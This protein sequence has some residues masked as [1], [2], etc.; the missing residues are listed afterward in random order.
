VPDDNDILDVADRLWRG[1]IAIEQ[2]HPFAPRGDVAEVADGC[3]FVPS[4]ANVSAV[5]TG[6]GLVLVDTGSQLFARAALDELR[7]WSTDRVDTAVYSHG[8]VDHVFGVPLLEL[9][10]EDNGWAPPTV[11]AHEALPARFDRYVLTAGYN[12]VINQRQFRVPN[13]R[14][15]TEY[16]YP[17]RTYRDTLAVEVGGVGFELHHAR[18]E[19]DDHTWTWVPER[20]V[21][22]CGDFFIWACPNAGN[23]F[24]VQRYPR[25]WAIALR[26]MA[27]LQPEVLL[28]GHGLP[29]M[30]ADRV[31][32]ALTDTAT[33]LESLHDQTVELMNTG[34]S[35]DEVIHTVRAP[36]ELLDRPY[37]QPIY[38]DP[39][40]IVHNVWRLY[41]GWWDGDPS[42]LKPAPTDDLAAELAGLAGGANRLADRGVEIADAGDLRLAA[43][44][45]ELAARAAPFD[46]AIRR[47]R[48]DVYSRRARAER[49]LMARNTF[50][51][52]ADRDS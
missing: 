34:A 10:A 9:E 3:A 14:W 27:E 44:L 17:D 12:E 43:H 7:R 24:K 46:D 20:K 37:L 6:D 52:A 39:E 13:L 15:P 21:L 30:G 47:A 4:F 51:W 32:Q 40:F 28:P 41:G 16:R 48:A 8:H 2:A 45:V 42:H 31:R 25:E 29:I 50:N 18:G 5:A 19:T 22:C 35:L 33:L 38:D 49:S 11:L 1:E 23:P 36:Q 26:A